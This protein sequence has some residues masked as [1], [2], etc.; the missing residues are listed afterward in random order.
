MQLGTGIGRTFVRFSGGCFGSCAGL[1]EELIITEQCHD[2]A[3]AVEG[4]LTK[5]GAGRYIAGALHLAEE[6]VDV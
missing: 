5:H 6:V 2:L 1:Q 4:E 3:I